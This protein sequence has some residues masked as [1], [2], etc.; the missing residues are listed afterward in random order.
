MF[1]AGKRICLMRFQDWICHHGR[2][3]ILLAL[4]SI[5]PGGCNWLRTRDTLDELAVENEANAEA[6][7][8]PQAQD[9]PVSPQSGDLDSLWLA[10]LADPNW[11]MAVSSSDAPPRYRYRHPALE[12]LVA[13]G[14]PATDLQDKL[15]A[16]ESIVRTNA[17]IVL[18]RA[19]EA[20]VVEILAEA[21]RDRE[22]KLPQRQAAIEAIGLATDSEAERIV[23]ELLADYG[24]FG[25]AF[26]TQYLPELHAELVH[27]LGRSAAATDD[28][29]VAALGSPSA[30]PRLEAVRVWSRD[31][32]SEL[33]EKLVDLR[34]D[35]DARIRA[36]VLAMLAAHQHPQA[37]VHL[38]TGLADFD[39]NVRLAA[40]RAL[41]V[42]GGD[43]ARKRLDTL[44]TSDAETT[45]A[46]A[47]AALVQMKADDAVLAAARD[48]SWLV[49]KEVATALAAGPDSP[50]ASLA[51]SLLAD[52]SPLVQ[53]QMLETLATWPK[54][55]SGP[56]LL[57]A[58]E[59]SGY[60]ARKTAR[61]QLAQHWPAAEELV[62]DAPAERRA[63]KLAELRDRFA[64]EHGAVLASAAL[65]TAAL[66]QSA[67]NLAPAADVALC[68]QR[69]HSGTLGERRRAADRLSE[70]ASEAT[71]SDEAVEQLATLVVTQSDALLWRSV[72]AAIAPH[73]SDAAFRIAYAGASHA[74]PE[75]R[76]RA[77][78]HL[79]AHGDPRHVPILLPALEDKDEGVVRAAVRAL[80]ASGGTGDWTEIEALLLA[81][82]KTIRLEAAESLA[83]L[84]SEKGPAA[85]QRLALDSDPAVR[86]QAA[87]V[88]GQLRN[89]QFTP[90][91]IQLLDDQG[92]VC[93]AA[94]VSLAQIVGRDVTRSSDPAE[95]PPRPAEVIQRWKEWAAGQDRETESGGEGEATSAA[96]S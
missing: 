47:V 77:C 66:A 59:H 50:L 19:G 80:G 53:Q 46:A 60:L 40:I 55:K 70:L 85:L 43:T 87:L 37:L 39:I 27:A 57:E 82:D 21:A 49:R 94:L 63:A 15:A 22:L 11:V 64:K 32:T 56:L 44:M 90:V 10:A 68:L 48:K 3:L 51:S 75:V 2:W 41:G 16:E 73:T 36:M 20:G 88:M 72:L 25:E 92:G 83:R 81:S 71:L 30:L 23:R 96:E 29:I 86:R 31:T 7:V 6:K 42:A 24:R 9:S 74:A 1:H 33:P 52:S 95:P 61:Q 4:A 69:L 76:R 8:E 28:A 89:P 18:A 13:D 62:L 58:L 65:K 38:Q 17:A 67:S 35:S 93:Q 34:T 84:G 12:P 26:K 91:L 14:I 79:A 5:V 78:L 54:E 45:R